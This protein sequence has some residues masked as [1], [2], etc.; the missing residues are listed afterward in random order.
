MRWAKNS[1]R[2]VTSPHAEGVNA[3]ARPQQLEKIPRSVRYYGER[4]CPDSGKARVF[5][6]FCVVLKPAFYDLPPLPLKKN[7]CATRLSLHSR[8]SLEIIL[9]GRGQ[10]KDETPQ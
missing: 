8:L 10:R 3:S 9:S 6:A 1:A 5:E 4:G 7:G 2:V